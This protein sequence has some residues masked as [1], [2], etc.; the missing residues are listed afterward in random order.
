M[1]R[2]AHLEASVDR[3]QTQ[4]RALG[5]SRTSHLSRARALWWFLAH[6]L[7]IRACAAVRFQVLSAWNVPAPASRVETV[8]SFTYCSTVCLKRLAA[9][10][11]MTA[12]CARGFGMLRMCAYSRTMFRRLFPSRWLSFAYSRIRLY[13]AAQI[14]VFETQR[15]LRLAYARGLS[16]AWRNGH[17]RLSL[18]RP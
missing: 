5:S 1:V 15:W 12:R 2:R 3:A 8:W 11:R 6:S 10:L 4:P 14:A 9:V 16:R 13:R 7:S 18:Y 17:T